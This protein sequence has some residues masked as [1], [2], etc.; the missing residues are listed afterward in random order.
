MQPAADVRGTMQMAL[1]V[2]ALISVHGAAGTTVA[3]C[4]GML[5]RVAAT[6]RASADAPLQS[7]ARVSLAPRAAH[8]CSAAARACGSTSATEILTAL[9]GWFRR[10]VCSSSF[11]SSPTLENWPS[12]G[13]SMRRPLR[14]MARLMRVSPGLTLSTSSTHGMFDSRWCSHSLQ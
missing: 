7:L 3:V 9:C 5:V 2:V 12:F 6:K 13:A 10:P 8:S 4:A 11:L 14:W 1:K